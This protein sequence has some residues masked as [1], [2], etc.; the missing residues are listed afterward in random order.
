VP[1]TLQSDRCTIT[2]CQEIAEQLRARRSEI[3]GVLLARVD[4]ISSDDAAKASPDYAQGLRAAIIAA[5]DLALA[6]IANEDAWTEP[7][8][9]AA[10]EQARRAARQGIGLGIVLRRYIAGSAR[11][12]DFITEEFDRSDAL[13][14]HPTLRHALH[15]TQTAL[16]DRL[17]ATIAEAYN[18]ELASTERSPTQQRAAL[19]T[20]LLAAD[21]LTPAEQ[22]QLNYPFEG[23]HIAVIAKGPCS[24]KALRTIQA[25][26]GCELL[27]VPAPDGSHWGWFGSQR[28]LSSARLEEHADVTLATGEP[29]RDIAGW[30]LTHHEAQAAAPFASQRP[31][32]LTHCA[33]VLLEAAVMRDTTLATALNATFLVPLE[34]T[35]AGG[36]TSRE[37]LRAYFES[38]RNTVKA[39]DRLGVVRNTL[40]KRLREIESQLGRPLDTCAA[41]VE[42]ALRLEAL[43]TKD[44]HK[45][46][47]QSPPSRNARSRR[48]VAGA[49]SIGPRQAHS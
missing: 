49:A 14:N 18:T 11:L 47:A 22:A 44:P 13:S 15:R 46:R 29:R 8:P 43:T 26:L 31:S 24:D 3:A 37:T 36:A 28:G 27:S 9:A 10:I 17:T 20:R 7:V 5:V 32:A 6:C 1:A 35:R 21:Y 4:D 48:E 42:V 34:D 38:G 45:H 16:L 33:D 40:M 23:W 39:A 25:H 41:Q 30:R 12:A 19:V 2:A